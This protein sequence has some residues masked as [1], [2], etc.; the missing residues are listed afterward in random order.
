MPVNKTKIKV[1]KNLAKLNVLK[2]AKDDIKLNFK[3]NKS[4]KNYKL[5]DVIKANLKRLF[6]I[7]LTAEQWKSILKKVS[8]KPHGTINLHKFNKKDTISIIIDKQAK[9]PK[10]K[11]SKSFSTNKADNKPKKK[12]KILSKERFSFMFN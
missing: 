3:P 12:I 9:M 2:K 8:L 5:S 6:N 7:E 1:N 11:S 4:A 10:F